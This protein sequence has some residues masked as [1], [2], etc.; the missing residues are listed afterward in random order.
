[1]KHFNLIGLKIL[2]LLV[3]LYTILGIG[4]NVSFGNVMFI[5]IVLGISAYLIGDLLI[6][7]RTNNTIATTADFGMAFVIIYLMTDGL[8]VGGNPFA[9]ALIS[10]VVV[11]I[12]EV[13]FHKYV[14]NKLN[15]SSDDFIPIN[16][17]N[18]ST[19]TSEELTPY[20]D[21]EEK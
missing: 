10:A 6:L 13:I 8:T 4:Y 1:M 2:L 15:M 17:T 12:C 18:F 7:S 11:G 19:E 16:R 14:A 5:S 9:A 20:K 21:E 3:V